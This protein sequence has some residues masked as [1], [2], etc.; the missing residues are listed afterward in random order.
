MVVGPERKRNGFCRRPAYGRLKAEGPEADPEGKGVAGYKL[1]G[2]RFMDSG[3]SDFCLICLSPGPGA[4]GCNL[5]P[6]TLFLIEPVTLFQVDGRVFPYIQLQKD[7]ARKF[8]LYLNPYAARKNILKKNSFGA[9]SL[10]TPLPL[11]H[12][13]GK[14]ISDQ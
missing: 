2:S 14:V 12:S 8:D 11:S 5:K 13:E 4:P 3:I 7:Q 10:Q 1:A 9:R 6:V